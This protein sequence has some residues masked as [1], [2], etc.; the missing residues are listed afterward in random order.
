VI[1][2]H[3][4]CASEFDYKAW[5]A[6]GDWRRS[7]FYPPSPSK[8]KKKNCWNSCNYPSECRWGK[9]I[10]IQPPQLSL[11]LPAP[12]L[13]DHISRSTTEREPTTQPATTFDSIVQSH[14]KEVPPVTKKVKEDMWSVL[15]T[16]AAK[17][18]TSKSPLVLSTVAEDVEGGVEMTNVKVKL[19]VRP[20]PVLRVF[21]VNVGLGIDGV[22][23]V[24]GEMKRSVWKVR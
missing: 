17:R 9:Q 8:K 16:S 12:P 20:E 15:L 22:D 7:C 24:I 5:K 4:A 23:H 14:A 18:K 10:S 1:K 21:K 13:Q 19:P 6:F 2:R 3:K 11:A